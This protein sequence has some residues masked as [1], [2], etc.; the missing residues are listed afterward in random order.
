MARGLLK[1]YSRTITLI[2]KGLDILAI[3][4]IYPL[5]KFIYG[6][7]QFD[8]LDLLAM[9]LA[10]ILFLLMANVFTLY[11][12]WRSST[13]REEF[14]TLFLTIISMILG[15][16]LL[17]YASKTT[18][19]FSRLEIGTWWLLIPVTLMTI[20]ITVRSI[21]RHFRQSGHN[22]R[23]VAI[24]GNGIASQ[25]LAHEF[26][27][28][29]WMG[30]V[31]AGFFD[32]RKKAREDAGL[33]LDATSSGNFE[34]LIRGAKSNLYD[35]IYVALPMKAEE[36]INRLVK[37]LADTSIPVHVV[38]DL[39]T[40]KLMNARTSH[41][42][43]IPIV[44]IY[45]S[46]MDD[47]E[48][49]LKRV[50]DISLSSIILIIIALPMLII[51]IAIKLTSP[52][53]VIFKQ[54]RYGQ[55]GNEILVWKFRTMLVTEDGETFSQVKK[56]DN[57]VTPLGNFLRRTSLDELP[58]FI[59]VLQ[60]SM[61]IVGP[62]PHP[63]AMNELYRKSIDG[64]MLRHIIKPGI[65]GWAQVNGWRG[66]TDTDEKMQKRIEYDMEYLK[67]WSIFLDLKIIFMT[68]WKGFVNKNAY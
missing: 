36:L 39:F 13:L 11:R 64:Y 17:A 12:S 28:N 7:T 55:S 51:A 60:G 35:E 30:I 14:Q 44:S 40:F 2:H 31:V 10:V 20:R 27:T 45:E 43:N 18:A 21:L 57:R 3:V 66:E 32:D 29:D 6:R 52:G 67:N 59:N 49:I 24:I 58:Q 26:E 63:I 53:P 46:P 8:A 68:I 15:L 33:N 38:P 22:I 48:A 65:T 62:R 16:L 23:S 41:I 47:L 34:D 61:S 56:N 54:R 1:Q 42:G 19:M 50:M 37:E 5:A 25:R 4:T 9:L